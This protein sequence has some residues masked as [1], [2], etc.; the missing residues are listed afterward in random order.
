LA[1]NSIKNP[2]G[3]LGATDRDAPSDTER[4]PLPTKKSIKAT[5]RARWKG[6]H[7]GMNLVGE[8]LT[9]T[10]ARRTYPNACKTHVK[11]FSTISYLQLRGSLDTE[12]WGNASRVF[13]HSSTTTPWLRNRHMNSLFTALFCEGNKKE[14]PGLW[15][16]A[17]NR[18]GGENIFGEVHQNNTRTCLKRLARSFRESLK[19]SPKEF[20]K[21]G[22][23]LRIFTFLA[24]QG[25]KFSRRRWLR[26]TR[27]H[28]QD[29]SAI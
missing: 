23:A 28:V 20:Q 2:G 26:T 8:A 21:I 15:R 29:C 5:S 17:Q 7:L 12:G 14:S 27:H 16:N 11:R 4:Y 13:A 1:L 22:G 18:G 9:V 10:A 24:H 19:D 25:E 6:R 3:M